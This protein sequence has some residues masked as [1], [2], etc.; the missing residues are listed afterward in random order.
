MS[1]VTL[2]AQFHRLTSW[3]SVDGDI[4]LFLKQRGLSLLILFALCYY[5]YYCR[6]WPG[7][8]GEGGLVALLAQ[9]LLEGQ[10][11]IVDTFLG[12][13]VLWFYPVV[14][15]FKVLGPHYLA[16][17]FFFFVLCL[18]TGLLS[19]GVIMKCTGR[20][21]LALLTGMLVILVPGQT[22]RNYMA[23]IAVLNMSVFLSAYVLPARNFWVRFLW[24]LLVGITLGIAYL[25]RIDVGYFLTFI[26]LGLILL[27]PIVNPDNLVPSQRIL[28]TLTGVALAAAG[29]FL[30]HLP[31]YRDAVN[32][33]FDREFVGQY[34][35]WPE[36]ISSYGSRMIEGT[37]V[38]LRESL[39]KGKLQP[40]PAP[41]AEQPVA[42]SSIPIV[43]PP[44]ATS[45]PPEK[46]LKITHGA[47]ERISITSPNPRDKIMALNL[48][49]PIPLSVMLLCGALTG[50]IAA[51]KRE[52]RA[53]GVRALSSLTALGCALVLFPQYF[54]WQP[55][56]VHLSEFMVPMT[57]ALILSCVMVVDSWNNGGRARRLFGGV[58]LVLA[59]AAL[60]LYYINGCQSGGGG[61]IAV[62][63][64]KKFPFHAANGA[65][66]LMNSEEFEVNSSMRDLIV[67]VTD[68]GDFVI[69]YPYHPE[70][71]FY[72][73]RP[74]YE[75]NVYADNDIPGDK[76]YRTLLANSERYHPAVFVINNW[77]I[78]STEESRFYNWAWESYRH[79]T[80]HYLL[81]YKHGDFEVYVRPDRAERIPAQF[82]ESNNAPPM[83]L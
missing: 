36:M 15:I 62:S 82:K 48:Y 28:V 49:L 5:G 22:Y 3:F 4:E 69:C 26:M 71:N 66:V 45:P 35:Q 29:F 43:P 6:V 80:E 54:F 8:G 18:V 2:R 37:S 30:T 53:A 41:I 60:I 17:R 79:L 10:R 44:P 31:V 23:F 7:P 58:Y 51:I 75:H 14:G 9:R 83:K 24:M 59:L 56:M 63:Q 19:F 52:N 46:S 32:R 76:F 73:D 16:M 1:F 38:M 39:P 33:G 68:P 34:R 42:P 78:N 74:S 64:H 25:I 57:V 50:W 77:D 47:Q 81:G 21:W 65:D 72:T 13:N 70:I 40:V 67:A 27:H 11:P 61:G 12:Y 20:A 55:N